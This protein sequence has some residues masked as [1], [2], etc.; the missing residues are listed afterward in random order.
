MLVDLPYRIGSTINGWQNIQEMHMQLKNQL[1]KYCLILLCYY[2]Y[3]YP[4]IIGDLNTLD[5]F[6]F[7]SVATSFLLDAVLQARDFHFEII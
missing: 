4:Q 6:S 1:S 7:S 5:L 3:K 2:L